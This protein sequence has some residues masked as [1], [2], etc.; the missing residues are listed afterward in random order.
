MPVHRGVRQR[1]A[2]R[3]WFHR[4]A[5]PAPFQSSAKFSVNGPPSRRPSD[6]VLRVAL[7]AVCRPNWRDRRNCE[8]GS[9]RRAAVLLGLAQRLDQPVVLRTLGHHLPRLHCQI[10]RETG[11]G[12]WTA[13]LAAQRQYEVLKEGS[14]QRATAMR[15]ASSPW[16]GPSQST[17]I[18]PKSSAESQ[19][20]HSALG[21]GSDTHFAH[22]P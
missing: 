7:S 1:E 6:T 5:S 10:L 2:G 16:K 8:T 21:R 20:P 17:R 13:S 3:S 15:L 22:Q 9:C 19:N 18:S 14:R 11:P 4:S 12:R